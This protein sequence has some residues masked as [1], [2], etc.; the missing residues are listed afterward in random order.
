ME[1]WRWKSWRASTPPWARPSPRWKELTSWYCYSTCTFTMASLL[2]LLNY[3]VS[4]PLPEGAGGLPP[5]GRQVSFQHLFG[6]ERK[7]PIK[8]LY[9]SQ[10]SMQWPLGWFSLEG[11]MSVDM[12]SSVYSVR[13]KNK[14]SWK[15]LVEECIAKIVKLGFFL[16]DPVKA[17]GCSTSTVVTK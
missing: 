17:W 4:T 10:F 11:T 15:H 14:E 13:D 8:Q 16:A 5:G 3:N 9:Y 7:P 6:M 12:L 1:V 2:L